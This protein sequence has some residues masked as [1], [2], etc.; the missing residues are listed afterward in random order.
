VVAGAGLIFGIAMSAL[1]GIAASG[2]AGRAASAEVEVTFLGWQGYDA[3]L[4]VDDWVTKNGVKLATTYIGNNDE[5]VTKLTSGG[6]GQIDLVTPYMG[7]IPLLYKT[8]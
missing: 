1:G 5:I 2:L 7:Y 3:P 8:G 4:L 6:I